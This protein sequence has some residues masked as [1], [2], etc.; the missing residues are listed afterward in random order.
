TLLQP[1]QPGFE[2]GPATRYSE[3]EVI[4]AGPEL[5]E[6]LVR[7]VLVFREM[8]AQSARGMVEPGLDPALLGAAALK[9]LLQPEQVL[10]PGNAPLNVAN[11]QGE[12]VDASD[13][14]HG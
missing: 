11:G 1:S 5:A 12:M 14:D 4:K 8:Q 10:V 6:G 9:G 3:G 2:R 13:V 7:T